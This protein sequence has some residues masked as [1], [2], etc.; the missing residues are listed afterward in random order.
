MDEE[1]ISITNAEVE[2]IRGGN[3][4]GK[5]PCPR[6]YWGNLEIRYLQLYQ[7]AFGMEKE[8]ATK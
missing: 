6:V 2:V 5:N 4:W 3:E 7:C 1:L 8:R